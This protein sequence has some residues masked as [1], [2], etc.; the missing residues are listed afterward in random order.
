MIPNEAG[1]ICGKQIQ[2]GEAIGTVIINGPVVGHKKCA[3]GFHTRKQQ[4]E[5][6]A[7]HNMVKRYDQG[8]AGGPID[9]N[10]ERD[11]IQGS[12]PLEKPEPAE[13]R[14]EAVVVS[15]SLKGSGGMQSQVQSTPDL[16]S[17][18]RAAGVHNIADVPLDATPTEAVEIAERKNAEEYKQFLSELRTTADHVEDAAPAGGRIEWSHTVP[19]GVGEVRLT[20]RFED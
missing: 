1:V 5:R 20:I 10:S 8:G 18:T 2:E 6:E 7:R 19:K 9:Y 13:S 17:I 14:A 4:S 3:D 15:A 16:A 12:L 11:G